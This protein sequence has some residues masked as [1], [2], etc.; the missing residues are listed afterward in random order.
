MKYY[1]TT[2]MATFAVHHSNITA[3]A[4]HIYSKDHFE[5]A[6]QDAYQAERQLIA[7]LTRLMSAD[8]EA[9]VSTPAVVASGDF[10]RVVIETLIHSMVVTNNQVDA[11]VETTGVDYTPIPEA[12]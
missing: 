6:S 3:I 4:P 12:D 11:T 10:V 1:D 5:F 2:E 8:E 9:E 7:V